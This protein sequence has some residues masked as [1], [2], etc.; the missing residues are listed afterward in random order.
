VQAPVRSSS[1]FFTHLLTTVRVG[2]VAGLLA[3]ITSDAW[4]YLTTVAPVHGSMADSYAYIT[5]VAFGNAPV[6]GNAVV[7]GMLAHVCISLGWALGYT[8]LAARNP[9]LSR[10]PWISGTVF[11]LLVLLAM[12][13]ILLSVHEFHTFPP[14]A[15]L[16]VIVMHTIFFGVPI[17]FTVARLQKRA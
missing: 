10:A 7:I 9:A 6:V 17:A 11:G 4:L 13:L 14:L 2:F 3:A 16:N 5:R 1:H 12:Q 8:D 15:F